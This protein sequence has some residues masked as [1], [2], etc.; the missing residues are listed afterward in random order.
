MDP[1]ED[2]TI[3]RT[4]SRSLLILAGLLTLVAWQFPAGRQLLYPFTWLAT[5][6]HEMGHGLTAMILGGH[7]QSLEMYADGSGRALWEPEGDGGRLT[8]AL[9]AAG[10]LVGPSVT[11]AV[12]LVLS[13]RPSRARFILYLLGTAL[14][15]SLLLVARSGFAVLFLAGTAA[16]FWCVSRFFPDSLAPFLVQL[17]GVQLCLSAFRDVGYMFSE[18]G[19]INGA[20]QRSDSAA[21]ADAL[22]L[23]YW[24]WG[25]LVAL[26]SFLVL[27]IGLYAALRGRPEPVPEAT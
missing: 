3:R 21:I 7:F 1:I 15:V 25:A 24:F 12:L 8:V 2:S 27:G 6:A 23:P 16:V 18:G 14:L 26:F 17:I 13:R 22:F 5:F 10:G 19:L 11:G 4:T 9:V 20:F